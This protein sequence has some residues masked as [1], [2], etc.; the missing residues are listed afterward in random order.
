[1]SD[2]DEMDD[3]LLPTLRVKQGPTR[4]LN[5]VVKDLEDLIEEPGTLVA[6]IVT[7]DGP[8]RIAL[9]IRTLTDELA[10][11]SEAKFSAMMV[12]A[13]DDEQEAN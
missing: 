10:V 3:T 2:L 4:R 13:K 6:Q 5:V 9:N 12:T 7:K 11:G 8:L 1:M